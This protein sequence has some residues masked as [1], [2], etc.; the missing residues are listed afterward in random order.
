M[1]I[2]APPQWCAQRM[3]KKT[4]L[5]TAYIEN[6][7]GAFLRQQLRNEELEHERQL[8]DIRTGSQRSANGTERPP[9]DPHQQEV[10]DQLLHHLDQIHWPF[11]TAMRVKKYYPLDIPVPPPTPQ[12][13]L[14]QIELYAI[15]LFKEEADQ[16]E[17]F[18]S[19]EQYSAWL[20][21]LVERVI[22]RVLF[23]LKKL[24][25]ADPTTLLV[26]YH[27]LSQPEI[28]QGMRVMLLEVV[29]SYERG[30]SGIMKA[31]ARPPLP[32]EIQEQMDAASQ[33]DAEIDT[34]KT[35]FEPDPIPVTD[36]S[37][38]QRRQNC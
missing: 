16:Y 27:G 24:E 11:I 30:K 23:A 8:A 22:T 21:R 2:P 25:G 13:L 26:G 12:H 29:Q 34:P 6:Q 7:R 1:P 37:E 9:F 19:N 38:V 35:V 36:V 3:P 31:P 5:I 32:P 18:R 17:Q 33:E 14:T 20:L 28:E 10:M 15:R 4:D